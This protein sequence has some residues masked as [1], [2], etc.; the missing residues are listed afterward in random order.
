[1]QRTAPR[2]LDMPRKPVI[3]RR[4]PRPVPPPLYIGEWIRALGM[5][6]ADVARATGRN[7]GYLSQLIN[8]QK[9]RPSLGLQ[10]EIADA[11]GIP[12]MYF[13]TPPPPREVVEQAGAIDPGVLARLR[14]Q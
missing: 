14:R 11:L 10:K 3:A 6:P 1:M 7:E 5:R 12:M 4:K 9:R 13:V 2:I 8:G